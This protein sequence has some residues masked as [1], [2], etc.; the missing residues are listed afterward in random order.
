M[1]CAASVSLV[2][3]AVGKIGGDKSE[4]VWGESSEAQNR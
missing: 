4:A 1:M 2:C 3:R